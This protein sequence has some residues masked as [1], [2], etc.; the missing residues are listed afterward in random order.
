M[1]K[2]LPMPDAIVSSVCPHNGKIC[3][4]NESV[5]VNPIPKDFPVENQV[6]NL[7]PEFT[8]QKILGF[9]GAMTESAGYVLSLLPEKLRKEAIREYFGEGG[10]TLLRV[11]VDSCDFS[12]GMYQ[13]VADSDPELTSFSLER[14]QRYIIPAIRDAIEASDEPISVLLSPWSPPAKWKTQ[15]S[16]LKDVKSKEDLKRFLPP[17][18]SE[19]ETEEVN[20]TLQALIAGL[21]ESMKSGKSLRTC[22]GHLK[23]EYY[24]SWARYLVKYVQAYLDE[25]IPVRWLS[26]QNEAQAA[27]PWDSCEWTAEEEKTFLRDYLYP[28][29][30]EAELTDRVGI[31]FWDHNKENLLDRALKTLDQHTRPM[32]AGAAFH[33]Y[34]GDHFEAVRMVRERF[35]ELHLICSECSCSFA[36]SGSEEELRQSVRYAH[37]MIENLNN[38]MDAWFDWNLFLDEQGGPNHVKNFCSAPIMLDGSGGYE[39]RTSYYFIQQIVRNIK[40]GAV[41]IGST[42]YTSE[43]DV[44]AFRNPNMEIVGI[45]LNH[46]NEE[47]SV[48][49]R[50]DGNVCKFV[51]PAFGITSVTMKVNSSENLE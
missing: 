24:G 12:L 11:P 41:R 15:P 42:K 2:N 27:T 10:Y 35:P 49:L 3:S 28:A 8:Y 22:G 26:I 31:L 51:I 9:G 39:K 21:E 37:D 30:A 43:L 19:V 32:V 36:P 25:G 6:V 4:G 38:G 34:S 48:N 13:A 14:D 50:L 7:Y 29:M 44:T 17:E 40:P 20:P 5:P 23:A 16:M 46:S 45:L 18:L 1:E 33:W 47:K